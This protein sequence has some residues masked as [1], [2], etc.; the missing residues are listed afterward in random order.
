MSPARNHPSLKVLAV[1]SGFPQYSVSRLGEMGHA[2]ISTEEYRD[3]H[4]LPLILGI[5]GHLLVRCEPDT[6]TGSHI[7]NQ[8][9]DHPDP[10]SMP[11]DVG[12][13]G[14]EEHPALFVRAVELPGPDLVHSAR[15]RVGAL[16]RKRS[17]PKYG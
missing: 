12:V 15:R 8:P 4:Q 5:S 17:L 10:G 9:F 2:L 16:A 14:G 6:R 11:D 7:L 3:S 1:A 13:H